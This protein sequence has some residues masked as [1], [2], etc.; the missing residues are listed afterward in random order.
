MALDKTV[1]AD[2]LY[3]IE[4]DSFSGMHIEDE[5][6]VKLRA[7]SEAIAEAIHA[8]ISSGEVAVK[9]FPIQGSNARRTFMSEETEDGG[10]VLK[11][12]VDPSKPIAIST[13]KGSIS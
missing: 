9:N 3:K 12:V 1:L 5:L 2:A 6:D 10:E 7:K 8:F 11:E 4:V 13:G